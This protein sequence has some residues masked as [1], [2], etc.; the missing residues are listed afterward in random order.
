MQHLKSFL[1]YKR[2]SVATIRGI[3]LSIVRVIPMPATASPQVQKNFDYAS[4][5]AATSRFVQ[6]QTGEIRA[7]MKRTAQGIVEIGQKLIEVKERIGHG[8]FGL[9]LNAEF[10]WSQDTATNFI[11]VAQRFGGNPKFSEFAPSALY[12]LAAPSTPDTVRQEALA[13]AEAGEF[14]TYSSAKALKQKYAP[15]PAKTELQAVSQPQPTSIPAPALGSRPKQEIVAILPHK[16]GTT[17]C[18]V[19]R[20]MSPHPEQILSIPQSP[21]AESEQPGVWWQLGGKHLLYCGNPNSS[22]FVGR[23]TEEVH[24]VQL[25]FAFPPTPDWQPAIQARARVIVEHYLLQ[26]KSSDQLDEILESN[27]LFCSRLSDL[28]I[29]CFLPTNESFSVVNR[30]DRRGFFAEPD[31]KRCNAI[32]TDWKKAGLKAERVN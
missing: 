32:I 26:G 8:Q 13:R 12:L 1:G 27:I 21:K 20:V 7:L 31:V 3:S 6:Q 5:D 2:Y 14:I 29:C 17:L 22:E 25:L 24:L 23:V 30:L 19:T 28:V 4:L 11:R 16:Q 9:W 15:A 10:E 18:E